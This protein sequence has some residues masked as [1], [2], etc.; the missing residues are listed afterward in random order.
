MAINDQS[1]LKASISGTYGT[2]NIRPAISGDIQ[3]NV[4]QVF[5]EIFGAVPTPKRTGCQQLG[6]VA[7][8]G[9]GALTSLA[10]KCFFIPVSLQAKAPF[11]ALGVYGNTT[12]FF[13]LEMW[14]FTKLTEGWFQ[15]LSPSRAALIE[16]KPTCNKGLV[17][18]PAAFFIGIISQLQTGLATY[19]YNE[20]D[21]KWPGAVVTVLA[22]SLFP[23]LS[24]K[25][26]LETLC[27]RP[28]VEALITDEMRVQER[29][30][31]WMENFR[32][33]FRMMPREK[34]E[35]IIFSLEEC[36]RLNNF[37][38]N[39]ETYLMICHS[40]NRPEEVEV[41][42]PRRCGQRAVDVCSAISLMAF[43]IA[44]GMYTYSGI[45]DMAESDSFATEAIAVSGGVVVSGSFF[46]QSKLSIIATARRVYD[47]T[48]D[49]FVSE[50]T[51][52]LSEQIH[53]NR[54]YLAKTVGL[55]TDALALVPGVIIWREYFADDPGW[56]QFF[57]STINASVFMILFT[58][59]LDTVEGISESLIAANGAPG[60]HAEWIRLDRELREV[61]KFVQQIPAE[62]LTYFVPQPLLDQLEASLALTESEVEGAN[63][64]ST[65]QV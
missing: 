3:A 31:E 62:Y 8:L 22:L 28:E 18:V 36:R 13:V 48:V 41:P 16:Q 6:Y 49:F 60:S 50:N 27:C 57:E 12:A 21:A 63:V 56:K 47:I 33:E 38:Q 25:R 32:L 30:I 54:L 15:P 7:S 46:Y 20:G 35:R 19:K 42:R 14:A 53:P 37:D 24:V 2:N 59:M 11:N 23:T 10:S 34:K 9:T 44:M 51:P 5:Y 26:S 61:Q 29:L 39:I 58:A 64:G 17:I 40:E 65:S 4:E 55:I 45:K 1:P 43:E 52:S